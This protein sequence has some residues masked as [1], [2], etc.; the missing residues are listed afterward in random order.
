MLRQL[1]CLV[2]SASLT[3]GTS[4]SAFARNAALD[5]ANGASLD[6]PRGAAALANLRIPLGAA[7]ERT[8][9]P[10][11]G[12]TF[13]FGRANGADGLTARMTTRQIRLVDLR[14]DR[15][16]RF[17]NARVAGFD[18][19]N[20]DDDKRLNLFGGS[21]ST[22]WVIGGVLVVGLG[23]C[24]LAECFDGDDKQDDD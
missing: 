20:L 7:P 6:A 23:V 2:V 15:G 14:L 16:A 1:T 9:E 5:L 21:N 13:G 19:A 12:L 4:P 8:E 11:F 3:A 22:P 18:L 10:A 24:L 17:T